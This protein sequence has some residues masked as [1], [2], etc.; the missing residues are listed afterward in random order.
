MAG[1]GGGIEPA[2]DTFPG[3]AHSVERALAGSLFG[4][5]AGFRFADGFP[6]LGLLRFHGFA[7]P[8]ASHWESIRDPGW[9]VADLN[10]LGRNDQIAVR[11]APPS[12]APESIIGGHSRGTAAANDRLDRKD[13]VILVFPDSQRSRHDRARLSCLRAWEAW[14]ARGRRR[15]VVCSLSPRTSPIP[16]ASFEATTACW[17][18]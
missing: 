2:K 18:C 13:P 12:W 5:E 7:L 11:N 3:Q 1:V 6:S 8:T 14:S 17:I 4:S 10:L 16:K 9:W 15:A